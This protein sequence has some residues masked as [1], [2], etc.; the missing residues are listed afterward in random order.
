MFCFQHPI[1][2]KVYSN[3]NNIQQIKKPTIPNDKEKIVD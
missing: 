2:T 1:G 3:E